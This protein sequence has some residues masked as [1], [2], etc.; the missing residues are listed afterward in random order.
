MPIDHLQV[1]RAGDGMLAWSFLPSDGRWRR[2]DPWGHR[3]LL[4]PGKT[5][6]ATDLHEMRRRHF[7]AWTTSLDALLHARG[8]IACRVC[9]RGEVQRITVPRAH[10]VHPQGVAVTRSGRR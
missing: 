10:F 4:S 5:F 8:L 7:D 3:H 9:L 1:E 6:R 2:R